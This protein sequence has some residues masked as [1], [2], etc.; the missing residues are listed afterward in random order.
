MAGETSDRGWSGRLVWL[1]SSR[2]HSQ[3]VYSLRWSVFACT[4]AVLVEASSQR[5]HDEFRSCSFHSST[6]TDRVPVFAV[7]LSFILLSVIC[8]AYAAKVTRGHCH[9]IDTREFIVSWKAERVISVT[10]VTKNNKKTKTNKW[11]PK[12]EI[13]KGSQNRTRKTMWERIFET[14]EFWVWSAI[15]DEVNQEECKRAVGDLEWGIYGESSSGR[16]G[17]GSTDWT[18]MR[19]SR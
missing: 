10:H 14:E 11:G 7:E 3:R 1:P 9:A 5:C 6:I 17:A 19:L 13:R 16:W 8:T 15:C 18:E 4:A 2:R 12:P